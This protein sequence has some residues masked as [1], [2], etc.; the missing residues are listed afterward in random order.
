MKKLLVLT[1][2]SI[3]FAV[4]GCENDYSDKVFDRDELISAVGGMYEASKFVWKDNSVVELKSVFVDKDHALEQ[5]K[6]ISGSLITTLKIRYFLPEFAQE[7]YEK[8]DAALWDYRLEKYGYPGNAPYEVMA[9]NWFL[10]VWHNYETNKYTVEI[11]GLNDDVSET[12]T[13]L[14][15]GKSGSVKILCAEFINYLATNYEIGEFS[16]D[17]FAAYAELLKENQFETASNFA[18]EAKLLK[19]FLAE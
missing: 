2:I 11:N 15:D 14:G 8:Y 10:S 6:E 9:L 12:F 3:V 1:L 7:N 17:N 4:C 18:F 16:E 13:H 5:I 19:L